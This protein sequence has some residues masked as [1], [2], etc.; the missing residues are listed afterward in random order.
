MIRRRGFEQ[1]IEL[2][3]G[4]ATNVGG[5]EVRATAAIHD[6][7]RHKVGPK[8]DSAGY[9]LGSGA[10]LVYFAG[11]TDLFDGMEDLAGD[12]D[13]AL[14]PI[15]GWG[16][17]VGSGHLDPR[18]A[19][20][21]A[22]MLRPRRAIPIHWGTLLRFDLG[23]RGDELSARAP[24]RFV[25]QLASARPTSRRSSSSP[26]SRWTFRRPLRRRPRGRRASASPCGPSA[27][28]P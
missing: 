25:A 12:I 15:A 17:K 10:R 16:P 23:R 2:G 26:A 24:R 21:A 3:T 13:V 20:A 7:R 4:Q 6:G 11:D 9:L 14:L 22:A 19:A 18:R 1:V 28:R 27:A 5:L 8:V